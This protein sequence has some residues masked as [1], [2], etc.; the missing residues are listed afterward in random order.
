MSGCRTSPR[1][2]GFEPGGVLLLLNPPDEVAEAV[3]K[4]EVVGDRVIISGCG[5]PG[6]LVAVGG[7]DGVGDKLVVVVDVIR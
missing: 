7:D 6:L 4:L 5:T 2:I 1:T 3:D